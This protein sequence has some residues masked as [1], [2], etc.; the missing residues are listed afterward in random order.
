MSHQRSIRMLPALMALFALTVGAC[1]KLEM[2]RFQAARTPA[3]EASAKA[4]LTMGT[5]PVTVVPGSEKTAHSEMIRNVGDRRIEHYEFQVGEKTIVIEDENL[6][7]DDKFYGT[8]NKG[9]TVLVDHERVHVNG[10]PVQRQGDDDD[11]DSNTPIVIPERPV[12]MPR[13]A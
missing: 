10:K 1:N 6:F 12:K 8:L 13:I 3:A 4:Q 7:V 9:D 11:H 5:H 2:Q